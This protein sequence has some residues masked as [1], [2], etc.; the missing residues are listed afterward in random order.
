VW[1]A[2]MAGWTAAGQVPELATLFPAVP[3]PLPPRMPPA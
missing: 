1:A 3:P 2:N